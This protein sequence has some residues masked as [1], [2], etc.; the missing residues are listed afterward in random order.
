M[1]GRHLTSRPAPPQRGSPSGPHGPGPRAGG[2]P[3]AP[4]GTAT[5]LAFMQVVLLIAGLLFLAVGVSIVVL[6]APALRSGVPVR[7]RLAGHSERAGDSGAMFHAV[8]E[9]VDLAGRRRL[10]ESAVGSN[11]PLGRVGDPVRVVLHPGHPDRA[12]VASPVTYVIGIVIA[13]L[14]AVSCAIFF[15]TF[16]SDLFSVLTSAA[17]VAVVGV[18]FHALYA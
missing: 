7:G 17:V 15:A 4:A 14:G 5:R 3:V 2:A 6:E 9:F 11:V 8:I 16:R 13:I 10:C 18:R 12:T 1:S